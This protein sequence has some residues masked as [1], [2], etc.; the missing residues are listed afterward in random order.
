MCKKNLIQVMSYD[1]DFNEKYSDPISI[2]LSLADDIDE[3][4]VS[5]IKEMLEENVWRAVYI[6]WF[7]IIC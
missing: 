2:A 1:I 3:R 6:R 5:Q 4:V 7:A